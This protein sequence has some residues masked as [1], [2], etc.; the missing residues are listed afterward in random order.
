MSFAEDSV[1]NS[2]LR[3]TLLEKNWSETERLRLER[4]KGLDISQNLNIQGQTFL[5]YVS[6]PNAILRSKSD[7]QK[8]L[9]P[10]VLDAPSVGKFAEA[11]VAS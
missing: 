5:G 4:L 8:S 6:A 3:D 1:A 9:N 11:T 7:F 10:K 2:V